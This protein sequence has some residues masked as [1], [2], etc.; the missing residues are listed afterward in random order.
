M[1]GPGAAGSVEPASS[2]PEYG[3]EAGSWSERLLLAPSVFGHDQRGEPGA[4]GVLVE[5]QSGD[6]FSIIS[7]ESLC[8]PQSMC[9]QRPELCTLCLSMSV[10][11]CVMAIKVGTPTWQLLIGKGTENFP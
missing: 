3:W 9:P 2:V 6:G 5:K 8:W 10:R 1:G 11:A 4:A 7:G